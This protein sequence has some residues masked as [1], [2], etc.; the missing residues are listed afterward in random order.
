MP[1]AGR[2]PRQFECQ[3]YFGVKCSLLPFCGLFFVNLE[4]SAI[5]FKYLVLDEKNYSCLVGWKQ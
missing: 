5:Y 3:F 2:I 4:Q 1:Q